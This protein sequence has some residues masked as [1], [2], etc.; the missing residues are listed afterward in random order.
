MAGGA[1]M[2]GGLDGQGHVLRGWGGGADGN[3]Q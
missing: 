1:D 3:R 2:R